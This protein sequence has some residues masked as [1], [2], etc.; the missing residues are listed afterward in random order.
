MFQTSVTAT[1][2]SEQLNTVLQV[3]VIAADCHQSRATFLYV[4]L[5]A[6]HAYMHA[7]QVLGVMASVQQT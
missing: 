2:P 7:L 3:R 1:R 6:R 4:C 5:I